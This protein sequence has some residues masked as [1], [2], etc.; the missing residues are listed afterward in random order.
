MDSD[1]EGRL[2][3]TQ[4]PHNKGL[5]PV[6][7]AVINSIESIE[8]QHEI[9]K[10]PLAEYCIEVKVIRDASLALE[11][12]LGQPSEG[13]IRE[14]NVTDNGIGFTDKNWI[15]FKTLDSR[16]KLEKGCRGIGRLM[17]LKA[18]EN[19]IVNST[20]VEDGRVRRRNFTFNVQNEISESKSNIEG[21]SPISTTVTLK[22]FKAP[23]A[24]STHKTL[25]KIASGLLEHC[26]W[27]FI[28]SEG[29]PNITVVDDQEAI[30]LFELFDAHMHSPAL[31]ES[32]SIKEKEFD[33]THVKIRT[34]QNKP[35]SLGYCASGRL[36]KT[37]QLVDKIP[38]LYKS[39][40]DSNGQF[41]YMAYLTAEY[42][43]EKVTNERIDF[44]ISEKTEGLFV[45]TE[46]SYRDMREAV[47]PLVK[48]FLSDSLEQVLEEGRKR[49]DDFVSNKVPRYRPLLNHIPPEKLSIDPNPYFS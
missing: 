2:R 21:D 18:F 9:I 16:Q 8:E 11:D 25:D 37:E 26:L 7:E 24:K 15:S 12:S 47:F 30:K 5:M 19:V 43:D 39:I 31:N 36:V 1:L 23:F 28:R 3:N 41:N 45:D 13:K 35:H 4:L 49:I 27:Y 17:W 44:N 22:G 34:T 48:I 6:Y 46:I 10:Q 20:Y 29:V 38:G 33:I 32:I 40:S 14:F 42:L